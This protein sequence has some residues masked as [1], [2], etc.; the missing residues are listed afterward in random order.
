MVA[1]RK[2]TVKRITVKRDDLQWRVSN[3]L[4]ILVFG[5]MFLGYG[6]AEYDAQTATGLL[7]I[8][9]LPDM[10]G[11]TVILTPDPEWKYFKHDLIRSGQ[12]SGDGPDS[13]AA[14]WIFDTGT[15]KPIEGSPVTCGGKVIFGSADGHIYAVNN[16][17]GQLLWKYPNQTVGVGA[18]YGS[19][20][21]PGDTRVYFG[22]DDNKMRA[23]KE[24][25]GTAIWTFQAGD[26]IKGSPIVDGGVVYFGS[27]DKKVY[28]LTSDTGAQKWVTDTSY[29][30]ESGPA[31]SGTDLF[32]ANNGY[33]GRLSTAGGSI[34]DKDLISIGGIPKPIIYMTT[35][36]VDNT[37]KKVYAGE[38]NGLQAGDTAKL[39]TK[40]K[41]MGVGAVRSGPIFSTDAMYVFFGSDNGKLYAVQTGAGG[42]QAG[43][44]VWD[45]DTSVPVMTSIAL[46]NSTPAPGDKIDIVFTAQY[47]GI[48]SVSIGGN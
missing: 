42:L 26:K 19:P 3:S 24:S 38:A 20:A 46:S 43:G 12:A 45:F 5:L 10:G 48:E 40:W 6:I 27:L 30:I 23:L 34:A 28:A 35:P 29:A 9:G 14:A 7:T 33:L 32:I 47:A 16:N 18:I 15:G 44:L 11:G 4:L 22:S 37:N 1:R 8:G 39:T 2:R 41:Y 21:C 31:L 25:D 36:A 17:T 13:A